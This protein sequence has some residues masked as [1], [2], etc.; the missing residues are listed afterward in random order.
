M[1]CPVCKA[2]A[3]FIFEQKVLHKYDVQ[4]WECKTCDFV[5]TDKPYWLDEAYQESIVCTDTGSVYR[6]IRMRYFVASLL[7]FVVGKKKKYLD[8]GGGYGIFVRMMRD[9]GFD[10][11]WQDKYTPNILAKGFE[12]N[13]KDNI[14]L[15]TAF[16]VMEHTPDPMGA[17]EELL[18][19]SDQIFFSTLLIAN[20]TP[21][22]THK[23]AIWWYYG[24]EHG[25]H[26]CFYRNKTFQFIAQKYNLNYYSDGKELHLF[27]KKKVN[28]ISRKLIFNRLLTMLFFPLIKSKIL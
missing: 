24:F 2:N 8:F 3:K 6:A 16:E 20:P 23:Q 1:K 19:I 25:Q 7:T 22:N 11:I 27:T 9:L 14:A 26:I 12:Y 17:I 4:Y 18:S 15:I 10:F 13:Q 21:Q 5:F 28:W